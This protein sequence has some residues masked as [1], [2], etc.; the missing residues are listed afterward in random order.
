MKCK[1]IKFEDDFIVIEPHY[2]FASN[3]SHS[4]LHVFLSL[5]D[6]KLISNEKE[7]YAK[8]IVLDSNIPHEVY[9]TSNSSLL[10]IVDS[11]STISDW[12]RSHYLMDSAIWC[13]NLHEYQV[14]KLS[15]S[16]DFFT[17]TR[18]N[19]L[20]LIGVESFGFDDNKLDIR[21]KTILESV[22]KNE[23]LL[24]TI[25]EI[26]KFVGLSTGRLSHL[27]HENTGMTLKNY[28]IIYKLRRVFVLIQEGLSITEAAHATGFYDSSHLCRVIKTTT[29]ITLSTFL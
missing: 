4:M 20:T 6:I 29:G 16:K 1:K 12:L 22:R 7:Y 13:G 15:E 14:R 24:F 8:H 17:T 25:P 18:N 11:C 21:I 9:A 10:Y 28:L 3:H 2:S 27:F 26:S 19:F 5:E 23:I